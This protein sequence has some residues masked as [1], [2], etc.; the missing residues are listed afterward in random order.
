MYVRMCTLTHTHTK[1][2]N[3]Y[4]HATDTKYYQSEQT[5]MT[6]DILIMQEFV[7]NRR[8]SQSS[9]NAHIQIKMGYSP[10]P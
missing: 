2:T 3:T 4:L 1:C 10:S 8:H 9:K 5:D 7:A 6:Y